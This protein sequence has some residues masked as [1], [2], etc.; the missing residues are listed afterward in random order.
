LLDLPYHKETPMP[1]TAPLDLTPDL[2]GWLHCVLE[3]SPDHFRQSRRTQAIL[4]AIG[5]LPLPGF[6]F[7]EPEPGE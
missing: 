2:A 1:E 7:P 3:N 6:A 4:D 5:K